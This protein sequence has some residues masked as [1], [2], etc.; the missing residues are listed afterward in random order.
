MGQQTLSFTIIHLETQE[1]VSSNY[2][3]RCYTV[4][5][6]GIATGHSFEYGH[7]CVRRENKWLSANDLNKEKDQFK[8]IVVDSPF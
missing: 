2:V 8:R 5:Q 3:S 6:F 7:E 4:S 1:F